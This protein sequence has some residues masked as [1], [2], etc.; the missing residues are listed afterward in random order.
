MY[1]MNGLALGGCGCESMQ[2]VGENPDGIGQDTPLSRA[3]SS[4][5]GS[6]F[7]DAMLGGVVGYAAAPKRDSAAMW[8]MAGAGAT[9]VAGMIGFG[10][11]IA[12]GLW[13]R[14]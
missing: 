14:R 12:A 7:V 6:M 11:V 3:S 5:T 13:Q 2:A 10:L 1:A 9:A 8:A 4:L